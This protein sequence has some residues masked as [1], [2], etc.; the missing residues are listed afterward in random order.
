MAILFCIDKLYCILIY[1][2]YMPLY[3]I[4][5]GIHMNILLEENT[6]LEFSMKH[7]LYLKELFAQ[8]P[9]DV[10]LSLPSNSNNMQENSIFISC[11]IHK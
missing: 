3:L 8:S 9:F 2:K 10:L 4:V 7:P 5:Y 1:V 6:S 11:N